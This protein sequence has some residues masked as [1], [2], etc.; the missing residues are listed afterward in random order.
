[1]KFDSWRDSRRLRS[2]LRYPSCEGELGA[3]HAIELPFVFKTLDTARGS[4]R[5][6]R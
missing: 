2:N 4:S 3:C 6:C 1:M 5:L